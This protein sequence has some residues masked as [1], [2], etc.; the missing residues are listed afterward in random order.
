MASVQGLSVDLRR[1][2]ARGTAQ[3]GD[4]LDQRQHRSAKVHLG[5]PGLNGA[6]FL[7]PLLCGQ[8]HLLGRL[9]GLQRALTEFEQ[10]R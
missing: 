4:Q 3:S 5:Q 2:G 8:E 10:V 7:F 1:A 6:A 9:E